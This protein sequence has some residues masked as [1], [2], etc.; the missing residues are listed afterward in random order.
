VAGPRTGGWR[1]HTPS[2]VKLP[3]GAGYRLYYTQSG[4]GAACPPPWAGEQ[5]LGC[6]CGWDWCV[7]GAARVGSCGLALPTPAHNP[8]AC[9]SAHAPW[10][11]VAAAVG[12]A[13]GLHWSQSKGRILSAFSADGAA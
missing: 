7:G 2:A 11:D 4:P 3:G 9:I 5:G 8:G 10:A 1:T 6:L 13:P 12:A